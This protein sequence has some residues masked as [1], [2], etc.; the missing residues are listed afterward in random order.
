[1]ESKVVTVEHFLSPMLKKFCSGGTFGTPVIDG[2]MQASLE[3]RVRS[4]AASL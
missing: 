2:M 4:V 3:K 1:M